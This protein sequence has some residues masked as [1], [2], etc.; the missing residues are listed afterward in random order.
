MLDADQIATISLGVIVILTILAPGAIPFAW[1]L[2]RVRLIGGPTSAAILGGAIAGLLLGA[3]VLG[4]AAPDAYASIYI[5]GAQAAAALDEAKRES[6]RELAVLR[7]SGV[8]EIAI[9]EHLAGV[10]LRLTELGQRVQSER[11]QRAL[12]ADSAALLLACAMMA[13]AAASSG[14]RRRRDL[15]TGAIASGFT[16]VLG[17]GT[18]IFFAAIWFGGF[19]TTQAWALGAVLGIGSAWPTVRTRSHGIPGRSTETDAGAMV[20]LLIGLAAIE[21][22][23]L[24]ITGADSFAGAWSLAFVACAVIACAWR[25][26][27]RRPRSQRRAL[28]VSNGIIIPTLTAACIAPVDLPATA[29]TSACI[30]ASIAALLFASDGRW[31]GAW[32]GWRWFGDAE[33]R[34][35]A[36]RRSAAMLA[37]NVGAVSIGAGALCSAAG[38]INHAGMIAVVLGALLVESTVGL[39][40]RFATAFDRNAAQPD[41]ANTDDSHKA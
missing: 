12:A 17:A 22:A 21:I 20:A 11:Q 9:S 2:R 30:I 14:R 39:R 37:N 1:L 28:M 41:D 24:S 40:L 6:E 7:A 32:L 33:T 31:F 29:L 36:W 25:V 8:S 23:I 19:T 26:G 38:L 34:Q 10:D 35:S 18:P 3:T 5:G 27:A 16:M 15:T 13:L 4:K